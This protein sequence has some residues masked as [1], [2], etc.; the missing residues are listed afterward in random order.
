MREGG[1]DKFPGAFSRASL[2]LMEPRE[3]RMQGENSDLECFTV[4]GFICLGIGCHPLV[5]DADVWK[6]LSPLLVPQMRINATFCFVVGR[7]WDANES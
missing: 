5:V 6:T 4:T 7:G 2:A 3:H 1:H